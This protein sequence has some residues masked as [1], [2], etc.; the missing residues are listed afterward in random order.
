MNNS[1]GRRHVLAGL[2]ASVGGL[3]LCSQRVWADDGL[4]LLRLEMSDG[5]SIALEQG[6]SGPSILLI[7]GAGA[8]RRSWAQVTPRLQPRFRTYAMDRRGH[9]DSTDGSTYSLAREAE[10]IARVAELLPAPVYVVGHSFGAIAALEALRLTGKIASAVLYEP[11]IPV[12]GGVDRTSPARLCASLAAGDNEGTLLT[13]FRDFVRLPEPLIEE[14][15]ADPTWAL[16]VKL[17]PTLCRE[18][19]IVSTYKLDPSAYVKVVTPTLFLLG[20]ASFPGMAT[21]VRTVAPVIMHSQLHLLAGQQHDAMFTAPALLAGE[22]GN[23]F[24]P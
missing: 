17:A 23:F 15:R 6:G 1:M 14:L 3:A 21:S 4:S 19:T 5:A 8:T 11:P 20:S 9:G 10:D 24:A 22:I 2:A 12:P 18:S 13:F 7:H 16:R